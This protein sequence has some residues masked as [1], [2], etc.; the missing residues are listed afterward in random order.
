MYII[1]S[2]LFTSD[3]PRLY[4]FCVS[5]LSLMCN[6]VTF[7]FLFFTLQKQQASLLHK[8]FIITSCWRSSVGPTF[9]KQSFTSTAA[10]PPP[11]FNFI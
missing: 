8:S 10:A 7:S 5:R 2:T 9:W 3:V 6:L 1:Y 4:L 11:R